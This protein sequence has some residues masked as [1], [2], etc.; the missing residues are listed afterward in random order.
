MDHTCLPFAPTSALASSGQPTSVLPRLNHDGSLDTTYGT[1]GTILSTIANELA[2]TAMQQDGN[3]VFV[4]NIARTIDYYPNDTGIV[5]RFVGDPVG[6]NQV[7][8]FN[9]GADQSLLAGSGAQSISNW[10]TG[11]S[12]GA[13][14]EI[15]Q[16]LDFVVTTSNSHLF[17]VGPTITTQGTLI[18]TPAAAATGAALVTVTLHDNGGTANGGSDT[19]AAQTFIIDVGSATPWQNPINP[20]DVTADGLVSPLDALVVI[21]QLN[22]AGSRLLGQLPNAPNGPADYF[23][24]NGDGAIT[25][26]D[27]LQII[28]ALNARVAHSAAADQSQQVGAA[29]AVAAIAFGPAGISR[30]APDTSSVANPSVTVLV[31]PSGG[32]ASPTHELAAA[33]VTRVR[34]AVRGSSRFTG[35]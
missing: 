14:D 30:T 34:A 23:D 35:S 13:A 3:L 4:G 32:I 11:I 26:L 22:A 16:T 5:A 8:T 24:V 15:G 18:Y 7:P 33:Q 28:N 19:S 25:P 29:T 6:S 27:A 9:K 12:T 17:T 20:L 10:A 31:G 21:N 1:N 2:S